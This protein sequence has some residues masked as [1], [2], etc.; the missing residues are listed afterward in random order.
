M[1]H[2]ID[3]ATLVLEYV[4]ITKGMYM[5]WTEYILFNNLGDAKD[6][7]VDSY[8]SNVREQYFEID[9]VKN[10]LISVECGIPQGSI[11]GAKMFL[12]SIINIFDMEFRGVLQLFESMLHDLRFL[13]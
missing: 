13:L 5:E 10:P 1:I 11:L 6:L 8:Y 4:S 7:L 12:I 9:G 2:S 3:S